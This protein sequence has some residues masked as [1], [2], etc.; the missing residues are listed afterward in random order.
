MVDLE[1]RLAAGY[2]PGLDDGLGCFID[3]ITTRSEIP[4]LIVL[5]EQ[6][7]P[8]GLVRGSDGEPLATPEG[9]RHIYVVGDGG[10]ILVALGDEKR[11]PGAV[12]HNTLLRAERV[13]AA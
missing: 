4:D 3:D 9:R 7:G 2:P 6:V 5:T 10:R 12:K 13:F 11:A 8:D 1:E